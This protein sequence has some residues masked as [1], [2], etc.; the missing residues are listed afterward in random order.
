LVK[1]RNTL[2]VHLQIPD[3]ADVGLLRAEVAFGMLLRLR[4]EH[5]ET[6][7]GPEAPRD[8]G[9]TSRV[10]LLIAK[11]QNGMTVQGVVHRPEDGIPKRPR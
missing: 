1:D 11:E 6:L 7:Q 2:A 4:L 5:L 8:R 3:Q 9:E 10:K